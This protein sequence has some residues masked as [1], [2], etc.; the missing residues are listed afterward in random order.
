VAQTRR[1]KAKDSD[2]AEQRGVETVMLEELA[3]RLG[4]T[5]R[6]KVFHADGDSRVELDGVSETPL[7]L[8][9][10]CAH[11]GSLKAGQTRKIVADAFKLVY[12]EKLLN[13]PARKI[14]LLADNEAAAPLTGRSWVAAAFRT[15]GIEVHV[16]S[17]ATELQ[18]R[19]R[20]AQQRQY[21]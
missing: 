18:E 14:L 15:L 5:L 8:C 13:R 10:A 6:P 20:V 12:V 4:I 17:L 7:V 1:L 11:H 21:R 19:V 16:A 2:S 9:E 3:G